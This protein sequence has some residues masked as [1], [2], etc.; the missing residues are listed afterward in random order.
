[1]SQSEFVKAKVYITKYALTRGIEE[2]DVELVTR[3]VRGSKKVTAARIISYAYYAVVLYP[4]DFHLTRKEAVVRA[5]EMHKRDITNR[6]RQLALK[7]Q[8]LE[9]LERELCAT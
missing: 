1:M 9:E 3:E 6:R 4:P 8:D 2:K 5:I 7:E